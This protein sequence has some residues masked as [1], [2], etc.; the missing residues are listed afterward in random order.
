MPAPHRLLT[1]AVVLLVIVLVAWALSRSQRPVAARSVAIAGAAVVVGLAI[2]IEV[3]VPSS[4]AIPEPTGA[5]SV[6]RTEVRLSA[7]GDQNAL[8]FYPSRATASAARYLDD[9][10]A[11]SRPLGVPAWVFRHLESTSLPIHE[12]PDPIPLTRGWIIYLHGAAS[13]PE[14]QTALLAELASN[15][16]AVLAPRLELDVQSMGLA[17]RD[18]NEFV[19]AFADAE[20]RFFGSIVEELFD[21]II[22]PE[23]DQWFLDPP[24]AT[25][26]DSI[27]VVGHSLGAGLSG[28]L[29][30]RLIEAGFRVPAWINLDGHLLAETPMVPQLHLSQGLAFDP[31]QPAGPIVADY[32]RRAERAHHAAG[33]QS[34]WYRI[35]AAGHASFT[36]LPY[37]VRGIGPFAPLVGS[38][39]SVPELV[40]R[41]VLQFLLDPRAELG[42]DVL[43]G[44]ERM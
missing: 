38:D 37:I 30:V 26:N 9:A 41:I 22:R 11:A 6:G 13:F 16:Y 28:A 33:D 19:A 35:P 25:R 5:Y 7:T 20:R 18:E 27:A 42:E 31:D 40:R 3:A 4:V 17:V 15:G 34:R 36:D 10:L 8:L 14:D 21:A 43:S 24:D 29:A 23:R 39:R 2:L 12:R 44:L 1:W 32:R